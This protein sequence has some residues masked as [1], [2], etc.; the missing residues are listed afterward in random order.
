M[1]LLSCLFAHLF[2]LYSDITHLQLSA[3]TETF[4]LYEVL[5]FDTTGAFFCG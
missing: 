1:S 5:C 2:F 4:T 3:E